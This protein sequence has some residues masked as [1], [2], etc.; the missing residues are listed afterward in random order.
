[1]IDEVHERHL[2]SD[3]LLGLL[4]ENL[5]VYPT[6]QVILMSATLDKE[7]FESYWSSKP[8]HIHIPGRTFPVTEYFLEDALRLT[9]YIPPKS[10]SKNKGKGEWI[11]DESD[12]ELEDDARPSSLQEL[13]GR[14]DQSQVDYDLLSQLVAYLVQARKPGDD[15]SILVFL[16]GAPEINMAMKCIERY[17]RGMAITT[18]PLHGGLQPKDQNRVFD[19]PPQG[20]T[21]VIF[22]TN[23]AETSITI[24][25]V[26]IVIDT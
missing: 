24:P 18:L 26:T 16:A 12:P 5:E 3:I 9:G 14:M 1:M 11:E 6:L 8:P 17:T 4:R 7:K 25:D 10:R 19:K 21:K 22:S 23:V 2:D 15:G 20:V 13:V